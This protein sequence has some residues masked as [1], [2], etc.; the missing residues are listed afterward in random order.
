MKIQDKK[1]EMALLLNEILDQNMVTKKV[2]IGSRR[3]K[4]FL[5]GKS[6][7]TISNILYKDKKLSINFESDS[8]VLQYS[9]C[10]NDNQS[11]NVFYI[12]IMEG[13]DLRKYKYIKAGSQL[14]IEIDKENIKTT[15]TDLPLLN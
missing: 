7:R 3:N 1:D 15:L 13:F 6:K 4:I 10:S 8:G 9:V 11:E 5:F 14:T 2:L 12:E